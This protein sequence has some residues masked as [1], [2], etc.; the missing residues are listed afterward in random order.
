MYDVHVDLPGYR[1]LYSP[2]SRGINTVPVH[3]HVHDTCTGCGEF[4][5]YSIQYLPR[6]IRIRRITA[7]TGNCNGID[8]IH[9]LR[10][11]DLVVV[12]TRRRFRMRLTLRRVIMI[13]DNDMIVQ[14]A[15]NQ[16]IL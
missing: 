1:Y 4:T 3:V 9:V 12:R 2:N 10:D 5:H 8:P 13:Y 16:Y 14:C 6:S 11:Q 15:V 7:F